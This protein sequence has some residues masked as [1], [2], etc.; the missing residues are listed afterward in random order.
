MRVT[1][2]GATGG[3]GR[4]LVAQALDRGHQVDAIVRD[5]G[6]AAFPASPRLTLHQGDVHD[7]A[8]IAAAV[9]PSSVVLSALGITSKKDAGTLTAGARAVVAAHPARI[10]WLGAIGTGRSARAV[11]RLTALL[12]RAGFGAEYGDKVSADATVLDA[13]GTVLHSGP[14]SGQPDDP[15]TRAVPLPAAG[16]RFFPRTTPRP[17]VARLMLDEAEGPAHPGGLI[18]PA[19]K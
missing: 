1:V 17:T 8:S 12:L 6:R 7:A 2:L 13:G 3:I 10:V 16:R 9:T 4:Q 15:A 11:G 19:P 5:P 14:F 18:V